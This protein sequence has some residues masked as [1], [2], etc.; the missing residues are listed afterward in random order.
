MISLGTTKLLCGLHW[1]HA[2]ALLTQMKRKVYSS[3]KTVLYWTVIHWTHYI[4]DSVKSQRVGKYT[5]NKLYKLSIK[6][7]GGGS[8]D[9][10]EEKRWNFY[11]VALPLRTRKQRDQMHQ[12]PQTSYDSSNIHATKAFFVK[13]MVSSNTDS[14]KFLAFKTLKVLHYGVFMW[15]N[16]CAEMTSTCFERDT[17]WPR[18]V[19]CWSQSSVANVWPNSKVSHCF[20]PCRGVGDTRYLATD[21]RCFNK[22][23]LGTPS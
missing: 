23:G 11:M 17:T 16:P 4:A 6:P 5:E 15:P 7:T 3:N 19:H 2:C 18:H 9:S 20:Q 12:L 14:P 10:K 8:E 21:V 1:V 22:W 13:N